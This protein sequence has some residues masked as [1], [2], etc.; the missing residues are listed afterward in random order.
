MAE[1]QNDMELRG[2]LLAERDNLRKQIETIPMTEKARKSE[3]MDLMH[4]YNDVKDATQTI[5]GGL[6]EIQGVTFKSIH[7][8]LNLPMND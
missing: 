7:K 3:L 5:I 6:A 1:K 8:E 2:K 4:T